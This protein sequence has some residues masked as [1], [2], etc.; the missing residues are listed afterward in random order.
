MGSSLSRPVVRSGS[1]GTI[2]PY[3]NSANLQ[4]E[5]I[6]RNTK[7]ILTGFLK[8]ILTGSLYG[9]TA[10]TQMKHGESFCIAISPT[11][12][13]NL[14]NEIVQYAKEVNECKFIEIGRCI[15]KLDNIDVKSFRPSNDY[16]NKTSVALIEIHEQL[17]Q[18][19]VLDL[20]DT[21]GE[22]MTVNIRD[23]IENLEVYYKNDGFVNICK[24]TNVNTGVFSIRQTS[25]HDQIMPKHVGGLIQSD[26]TDQQT[27]V[28]G[29]IFVVVRDI[30]WAV[31]MKIVL[32]RLENDL[33]FEVMFIQP[34]PKKTPLQPIQEAYHGILPNTTERMRSRGVV[35]W[36]EALTINKEEESRLDSPITLPSPPPPPPRSYVETCCNILRKI[37]ISVLLIILSII[38]AVILQSI[39]R[40]KYFEDD[41]I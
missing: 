37:M 9:L 4:E 22:A 41:D 30:G 33:G 23:P 2:Y 10:G 8:N 12:F 31:P 29:M 26:D 11:L 3:H 24:V 36:N 35:Y 15:L 19:F 6:N 20:R 28:F 34:P 25:S 27:S 16:T 14:P 32:E 39:E 38:C 5:R 13:N 17:R 21:D 18:Y 7:A 40:G 1:I